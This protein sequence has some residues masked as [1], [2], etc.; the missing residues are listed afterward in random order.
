MSDEQVERELFDEI[1][2]RLDEFGLRP[3]LVV[4]R[5]EHEA[6]VLIS[7]TVDDH[8]IT[9]HAW[10][11]HASGVAAAFTA[12]ALRDVRP[13]GDAVLLAR[14]VS[15]PV[16][17]RLREHGAQFIDA[18]GN[19]YI[20]QQGVLLWVVGRRPSTTIPRERPTRAFR[21]VGLQV[22]FVLL[23]D[24]ELIRAPYR[25]IAST[26]GTSLGAVPPVMNELRALGHIVGPEEHRSLQRVDR[27]LTTWTD[28]CTQ[29]LRPRLL[30]DRFRADDPQWWRSIDPTR[31]AV[32]WGGETAASILTKELRPETTTIYAESLPRELIVAARLRRDPEGNVDIRKRFW[33]GELPSPRP[34]VVPPALIYADLIA[35]GDARS[36]LA[37]ERIRGDYLDRPDRA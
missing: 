3:E 24:R 4:P 14:H 34:D 28:A 23:A 1:A 25:Q 29:T 9:L 16:A 7:I 30:L 13:S 33:A 19:M 10:E 20:R 2:A 22:I 37:A 26:A 15:T 8:T 17:E 36:A 5:S 35:A 18:S 21:R 12:N 31:Y 11:Q 6:D 27:L 32:A